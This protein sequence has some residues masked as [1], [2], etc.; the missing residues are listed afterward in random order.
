MASIVHGP[1]ASLCAIW[2]D[3]AFLSQFHELLGPPATLYPNCASDAAPDVAHLHEKRLAATQKEINDAAKERKESVSSRSAASLFARILQAL[4]TTSGIADQPSPSFRNLIDSATE[5]FDAAIKFDDQIRS[6]AEAVAA[7]RPE[8]V[9][10]LLHELQDKIR[11]LQEP[12]QWVLLLGCWAGSAF[13]IRREENDEYSFSII[14][15]KS[16][17]CYHESNLDCYPDKET[18]TALVVPR[19]PARRMLGN[20]TLW[21][22]LHN[23]VRARILKDVASDGTTCWEYIYEVFLPHLSGGTPLLDLAAGVPE[24]ESD[25]EWTPTGGSENLLHVFECALSFAAKSQ[26]ALK[27]EGDLL[28]LFFCKAQ[29][30]LVDH[31]AQAVGKMNQHADTK[32]VQ[33]LI[34][35]AYATVVRL[36]ERSVLSFSDVQQVNRSMEAYEAQ[37]HGAWHG[38]PATS[39]STLCSEHGVVAINLPFQ[40]FELVALTAEVGLG[41]NSSNQSSR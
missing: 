41:R 2:R 13:I 18:R 26:P 7:N 38:A 25:F 22:L 15:N 28:P 30:S 32:V 1:S 21:F 10:Q 3:P 27:R 5:A 34:Q 6:I 16:G 23:C 11:A 17:L 20:S 4:K 24:L 19:I 40:N 39:N 9:L 36:S 8:M 29:L 37:M 31:D 12:G 14:N 33:L 35:K